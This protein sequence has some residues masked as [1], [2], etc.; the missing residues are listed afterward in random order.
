VNSDNLEKLATIQ[1]AMNVERIAPEIMRTGLREP[2][3]RL[4]TGVGRSAGSVFFVYLPQL[5]SD[6]DTKVFRIF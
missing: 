2:L 5:S 1:K 3:F 6:F 4:L